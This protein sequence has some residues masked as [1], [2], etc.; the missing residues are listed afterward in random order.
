M[1]SESTRT[2]PA[3]ASTMARTMGIPRPEPLP[4]PE[5]Q[6]RVKTC[7]RSCGAIPGPVSLTVSRRGVPARYRVDGEG[8]RVAGAGS[9]GRSS[10]AGCRRPGGAGPASPRTL[11]ASSRS[12]T[13]VSP[14]AREGASWASAASRGDGS[15]VD[16]LGPQGEPGG[17]RSGQLGEV[18]DD[19][20]QPKGLVVQ[21]GQGGGVGGDQSVPQF[22]Q[23]RLERGQRG[24]QLVGDVGGHLPPG[25]LAELHLGRRPRR[26]R[27]PVRPSSPGAVRP[28]RASRSPAAKARAVAVRARQR[29]GEHPGDQP[30][31]G[32]GQ[33]EGGQRRA[34]RP[35]SRRP[36]AGRLQ[37]DAGEDQGHGADGCVRR[38]PR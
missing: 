10:A 35:R 9:A 27:R 32:H 20:A 2:L 5:R 24:T 1:P 23:A 37:H 26:R 28:V 4:S 8:D 34:R 33:G 25:L 19:P 16:G 3:W 12:R 31:G 21:P 13:R 36:A 17:V 29:A 38:R 7:G 22:L 18:G 6:K 15:E 11:T 14:A 30:G